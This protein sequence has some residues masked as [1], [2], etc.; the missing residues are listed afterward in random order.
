MYW[1][2]AEEPS[3]E[4]PLGDFFGVGHAAHADFVSQP[5][6]VSSHGRA[7]SCYWRMPFRESARITVTNESETYRTDSLYFYVDWEQHDSLPEKTPYFHA[8]YRQEFPAKPGDYVILETTGAGHYVGTVHSAHQV[9]IGWYGEGD[10]RFYIDGEEM[11]SLRGT[12]TEDYFGDAWGFRMFSTPYYGVSLWEGY[13]PG[14]RTTAYRWHIE[15]PVP[16]KESLKVSIEHRGSVFTDNAEH[17]G[18]FNERPDWVSSVAFWYQDPPVPA[19]SILPPPKDRVAPYDVQLASDLEIQGTSGALVHKEPP[20]VNFIPAEIENATI[21]FVFNVDKPGRYQINSLLWYSVYGGVY[22]A[23]LDGQSLGAPIDFCASGH[24]AVWTSF[25]LHDLEAG[26][27][28]LLFQSTG[29]SPHKRSLTP[30]RNAFGMTYLI[31]LRLE[32]M[33]GYQSVL[34]EK[35][36]EK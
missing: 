20:T 7:R 26:K 36:E 24:D 2:G 22:E 12:G 9:E 30:P 27:H 23:F 11:P 35:T 17:L 8:K 34:K 14:D 6:A 32:D 15:D 31:L 13:Y 29:T 10:D 28:T 33:E 21:E 4:A 3:V 16:F 5:V 25:D 19:N 18:Q 1:D